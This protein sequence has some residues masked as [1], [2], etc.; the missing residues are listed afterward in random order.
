MTPEDFAVV[1]LS[2]FQLMT[3]G[4]GAGVTRGALTN[5]TPNHLN[6]HTDMGEYIAAK[7]NLLGGELPPVSVLNA[8][9]GNTRAIGEGMRRPVVWFTGEYGLPEGYLPDVMKRHKGKVEKIAAPGPEGY[10]VEDASL[11]S[12]MTEIGYSAQLGTRFVAFA[13]VMGLLWP[14]VANFASGMS[15]WS[16]PAMLAM[17]ALSAVSFALY[18]AIWVFC[19]RKVREMMRE[20][21]RGKTVLIISIIL[22]CLLASVFKLDIGTWIVFGASPIL[23]AGLMWV[24]PYAIDAVKSTRDNNAKKTAEGAAKDEANA[25]AEAEADDEET[26]EEPAEAEAEA[27]AEY[28]TPHTARNAALP[29]REHHAFEALYPRAL[30][31]DKTDTRSSGSARRWWRTRPNPDRSDA[32]SCR[33]RGYGCGSASRSDWHRRRYS[34]ERGSHLRRYP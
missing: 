34:P 18:M 11:A 27:E 19:L 29:Y 9:D 4:A 20:I 33:H 28:P 32:A 16:T 15:I 8:R 25:E 13:G 17:C 3:M 24:A 23:L 10:D 1:E 7:S 26:G 22:I 14:L 2:S 5:I 30:A 21:P 12:L 6:W 31:P